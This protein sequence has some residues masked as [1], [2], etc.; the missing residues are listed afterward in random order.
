M[1]VKVRLVDP[2]E[3]KLCPTIERF[4][5]EFTEVVDGIMIK[6]G[7][8]IVDVIWDVD[9]DFVGSDGNGRFCG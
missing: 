9:G 8:W 3:P 4:R 5:Q 2:D 1:C 7:G 6:R